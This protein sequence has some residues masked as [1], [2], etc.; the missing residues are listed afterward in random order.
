MKQL[1]VYISITFAIIGCKESPLG[2]EENVRE[3]Y[4]VILPLDIDNQW[5][6]SIT[7]FDA[8]GN[9]I[10]NY[11]QETKISDVHVIN[12][13]DWF[14]VENHPY[15]DFSSVLLSNRNN[16]QWLWLLDDYQNPVLDYKY[17]AHLND[18]YHQPF[19]DDLQATINIRRTVTHTHSEI[20]V[21]NKL[22]TCK[23]YTDDILNNDGSIK[24][25]KNSI[26]YFTIDV[27][28]V[29][30]LEYEE[31]QTEGRFLKR[32]IELVNYNLK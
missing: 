25:E 12:N 2:L 9:I 32:Q 19:F 24:I 14:R 7:E 29:K 4:S 13:E 26:T 10:N 20:M 11:H 1:L 30:R 3:E 16:G 22:Y 6:Y 21:N 18:Q 5:T 15:R 17:A 23:E 28:I 27:G 8:H 31:N